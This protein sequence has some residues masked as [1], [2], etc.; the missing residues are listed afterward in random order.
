MLKN[1]QELQAYLDNSPSIRTKA[2]VT[3][4]WNMNRI[5]NIFRIGNYRYRPVLPL[6]DGDENY[7]FIV[8]T[9]DENDEDNEVKFYTGATLSDITVDGGFEDDG[10]TPIVLTEPNEKEKLYYSLEQCFNRFRPR[11]GINKTRFF[12]NAFTHHENPFMASRPRYYLSHKDDVF[13]YWTSYRKEDG[14][15][16]GIANKNINNIYYIDDAAPF[17][18]YK[19]NIAANRIVV[20]MQTNVGTVSL[21]DLIGSYFTKPDPFFGYNNQTTPS[22]WKI[23]V[24]KGNNWVDAISFDEN[25]LRSDD[26]QIIGPDGYVEIMYG[27]K[28][29]EEYSANFKYSGEY[30]VEALLPVVANVGDAFL[31]RRAENERGILYVWNGANYQNFIPQYGWYLNQSED[32]QDSF[33]P[34]VTDLTNPERIVDDSSPEEIYREFDYIRGLRVVVEAMNKENAIFDLIELSPRLA[35]DLTEKTMSFEFEKS[36]SDLGEAGLPVGELLASTGD[37]TLFDYDEAFNPNNEQSIFYRNESKNFQIKFFEKVEN[38]EGRDYYV[39]LKIMYAEQFP[40]IESESREISLELRDLFFYLESLTATE[41]LIPDTSL[42]YAVA[43]LLDSVGFSNY[44]FYRNENE[45]DFRVPFFFVPPNYTVAEVLQ[46][47]AVASQSAIFFDEYNNL[48]VMSKEYLFPESGTRDVSA[49]LRG[50]KDFEK[51]GLYKNNQSSEYLSNIV[52]LVSNN[53]EIYNAGKISYTARYIQKSFSSIEQANFVDQDKNW[54]Y[55]PAL[56]WEASGEEELKPKNNESEAQE[57]YVLSAIALNTDLTSDLPQVVNNELVNNTIDLGEGVYWIARYSGYYH[58]NGEV[59]RYDAIEFSISGTGNVWISS[60]Q[61]YANY[62]AQLPFN[63]KIYPTGLVRIYSEPFYEEVDGI[64]RLKNGPVNKHGRGQFGTDIKSHSAGLSS[65]WS[66]DDHVR[67]IDMDSSYLFAKQP[68]TLSPINSFTIERGAVTFSHQQPV[69][70]NVVLVNERVSTKITLP[71]HGYKVGDPFYFSV[72]DDDLPLGLLA[73]RVYF[74][75]SVLDEDSFSF[76]EI[77]NGN[78]VVVPEESSINTRISFS[79]RSSSQT[80]SSISIANPAVISRT[81]HGLKEGDP[82]YFTTT[83]RLPSGISAY[84][85]YY[86]KTVFASNSFSIS[87]TKSGEAVVTT[88]SPSQNGSHIFTRLFFP[89]SVSLANHRFSFDDTIGFSTTGRL[90]DGISANVTYFVSRINL[91]QS[92]FAISTSIGGAPIQAVAPTLPSGQTAGISTVRSTLSASSASRI[93]FVPST[94]KLEVGQRLDVVYENTGELNSTKKT[95]ISSIDEKRSRITISTPVSSNLRNASVQFTYAFNAEP[96]KAGISNT[97]AKNT[98][99]NGIIKNFLSYS[100]ISDDDINNFYATQ[101][102][103]VQSSALV[104]NGQA[105]PASQNPIDFVTYVYKKLDEDFNVKFNHFGT[106]MRIIGKLKSE[107]NLQT[108][109]GSITYFPNDDERR[110]DQNVSG[111]SGGIAVLINPANN[112][113]Y[114]FEIIATERSLEQR[115]NTADSSIFNVVFYKNMKNIAAS[116][117]FNKSIPIR[118]WS[119]IAPILTDSGDFVGQHRLI[120]EENPSVYDLAVEYEKIGGSLRFYLYINDNLVSVVDDPNPLPESPHMALF[121]RGSARCMFEHVY[122]LQSNIQVSDYSNVSNQISVDGSYRKYSVGDFIQKKYLNSISSLDIPKTHLFFEEFG[123]ILREASYFNIKYDKAF[124]ALIAQISPTFNSLKGYSVAGFVARSY[125]A[126]FLIFNNTDAPLDLNAETGNYLRIQGVTFTQESE[127]EITVDDYFLGRSNLSDPQVDSS[128]SIISPIRVQQE[129][130]NIKNQR[131]ANGRKEFSLEAPYLQNFDSATNVLEWLL[132]KITR[133]RKIVEAEVFGMP[134]V[135]LG[136][137][138]SIDYTGP[139]GVVE[140]APSQRFIVY[141]I[142]YSRDADSGPSTTL[143]LCEV[144]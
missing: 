131:I 102:G 68:F 89:T 2:F 106:R 69:S 94:T 32:I 40:E 66:S 59:V 55:T 119:G 25:S 72:N 123:T 142:S 27:L 77:L 31:V 91:S 36:I 62:F 110:Q 46:D 37:I 26:S 20:K 128:N 17:I 120:S 132:S 82:I 85:V 10:Q 56:I 139:G 47:L 78:A 8:E 93:L 18:V 98:S 33:L 134:T 42:S 112:N 130:Q 74:V 44:I 118:L 116:Q 105:F 129:Y 52:S 45:P 100:S 50:T 80:V 71:Q 58:L 113:G 35:V 84:K 114:F 92:Q 104:M 124:P 30:S 29:P 137:I 115:P 81:N 39:P 144:V 141:N 125:G 90:P 5:E 6:E 43:T 87:E 57:G 136:D 138:V 49:F 108:A 14:V 73:D 76:S 23:Q 122:A 60:S 9:F 67:G 3:A 61:E 64:T 63:G 99:R 4:E 13:K 111:S 28:I 51:S 97:L 24:L 65:Y 79:I 22:R 133:Q 75:R 109:I 12:G 88:S 121:I 54:I 41:M 1:S 135:K 86:V 70:T 96:G 83:G 107:E 101:S 103:T 38:V 126:E 127:N 140:F 11:S 16:R 19:Q 53:A 21:G 48:I 117:E 143:S 95:L 15:E 34:Y 7:S